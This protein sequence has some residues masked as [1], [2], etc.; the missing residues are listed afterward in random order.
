[1]SL[2]SKSMVIIF[3][4]LIAAY[5]L[6]Y[7][8]VHKFLIGNFHGI[9]QQIV[10]LN[11]NRAANNIDR[12][13]EQL[14]LTC[15]DYAAWSPTYQYMQN[16]TEE[17]EQINL[18][19]S[20]YQN[21]D[22]NLIMIYDLEGKPLYSG[23]FNLEQGKY[24]PPPDSLLDLLSFGPDIL[25]RARQGS[26][27]TGITD[28]TD[29]PLMFAACPI[30]DGQKTSQPLGVMLMGR[31]LNEQE[32]QHYSAELGMEVGI[33]LIKSGF[34]PGVEISAE[35]PWSLAVVAHDEEHISGYQVLPDWQDRPA[36][37]LQVKMLRS[38]YQQGKKALQTLNNLA[39]VIQFLIA[40]F[41]LL[42][43]ERAILSRIIRLS[44]EV[45]KVGRGTILSIPIDRP[46]KED[47]ITTL[48][49]E[50]NQMLQTIDQSQNQIRVSWEQYRQLF[51][52]SF[53]AN[54][55]AEKDGTILLFNDAFANL[56]KLN[57]PKGALQINLF[58]LYPGPDH[59][60][61]LMNSLQAGL[62]FNKQLLNLHTV[63]G[64]EIKVLTSARG[65]YDETGNLQRIQGYLLD[66]TEREQTQDALL[67]LSGHDR[68]TGLYNRSFIEN[69]LILIES[70]G[71]YPFSIIMADVNG[72]K[73][74][75]DS[76][77]QQQG[78]LYLKRLAVILKQCSRPQDLVA[79]WGGDE[80]LIVLP[81]TDEAAA[82]DIATHFEE[83]CQAE[84]NESSRIS[85]S[86]GTGC[87]ENSLVNSQAVISLAEERMYRNKLLQLRSNRNAL[88]ASLE[89]TLWEKSN[90]TEEHAQRLTH[91]VSQVGQAMNLSQNCLDELQLLATLHDIGKIAVPDEILEKRGPLSLE[92]WEVIKKHS[93]IGYRI[94]Q[95]SSEMQPIAEAILSHH[96]RWDGHGYPMGLKGKDIPLIARILAIADAYD[97]MTHERPY[98][99]PIS[100]QEAVDQL[101]AH[102]GTQFDPD[103]V[104]IF[105]ANIIPT[106]SD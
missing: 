51:N 31:Y 73:M 59:K 79:R 13:L 40:V 89:K 106:V 96:E 33:S 41:I 95:F 83:A 32:L 50:I 7:G 71:K 38:V 60:D 97:V 29:T 57:N 28:F 68:L 90:E 82:S 39:I 35:H 30:V 49:D 53:T 12:H 22:V 43:L 74:I 44:K 58:A 65:I 9:E 66:I 99:K 98:K 27:A 69:E 88:I 36:F 5:A 92:E 8:L 77:G 52:D 11:V 16:P 37:L 86:L 19:P 25:I 101:K 23:A 4:T 45:K 14:L 20:V 87:A 102:A 2:R 10:E 24:I 6:L 18:I 1:M 78:D 75:N 70:E 85:I 56:F 100:H 80:F 34:P 62:P 48:T 93:E 63:D 3:S 46:G 54:F 84:E 105:I 72:L 55:I 61:E 26:A 94:A 81:E 67:F 64:D 76:F 21:I 17:Y 91:L 15:T 103:L 42:A 104:Q 47:E